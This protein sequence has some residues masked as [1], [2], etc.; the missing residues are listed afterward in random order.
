MREGL[1]KV[2]EQPLAWSIFSES[3]PTANSTVRTDN[4]R[5]RALS[6]TSV[7]QATNQKVQIATS[8]FARQPV[9]RR[10]PVDEAKL[11]SKIFCDVLDGGTHP[12]T[13]GRQ[14]ARVQQRQ[15]QH[16]ELVYREEL[17]TDLWFVGAWCGGAVARIWEPTVRQSLDRIREEPQRRAGASRSG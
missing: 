13:V 6:P 12:G 9:E 16:F 8:P 1:Q 17:G 5:T 10:T 11:H 15:A 7:K 3:E 14:E 2:A 4:T